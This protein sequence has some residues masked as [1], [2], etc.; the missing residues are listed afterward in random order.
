ML[1]LTPSDI[2][3]PV[4]VCLGSQRPVWVAHVEWWDKCIL[5]T[6][7]VRF[8]KKMNPSHVG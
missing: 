8:E 7:K 4:T 6:L 2:R 1:V 5:K 3:L